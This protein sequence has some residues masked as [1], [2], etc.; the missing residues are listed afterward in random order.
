MKTEELF[1]RADRYN[2]VLDLTPEI[3]DDWLMHCNPHNRK[4]MDNHVEYLASE[5]KAGRWRLT[6]QGI[7]FSTNRV[8][9]DGQHRLWAVALS[10]VTVPMR[11]FVNEP[12]EA[13]EALDT[14]QRRRN[15]QILT[16]TAGLGE[17]TC[18]E[19]ATLR[20]MYMG[21]GQRRRSPGE[22]GA[23]LARHLDAVRFALE[24]LGRRERVKN[25]ATAMTRAVLA[26]AWYSAEHAQL[27]HFADVLTSGR[28]LG[29][30]DEPIMLLFQALVR[31]TH[32]R[33]AAGRREC[34]SLTERALAAFLNR[35]R[36][37]RLY[38][39]RQELFPLPE[40]A[41]PAAA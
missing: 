2:F 16:L 11:V 28:P 19:L 17:V 31:M 32:N 9:L 7:A 21:F 1:A 4:L 22:E 26:R 18:K 8:L 37:T 30:H 24:C 40:E 5:M 39:A 6:H 36:L 33:N 34:Y 20:A 38:P 13:M 29:E 41:Q 27:R 23:L 25:V 35:E 15:D 10:G 14:G 12:P 3:A